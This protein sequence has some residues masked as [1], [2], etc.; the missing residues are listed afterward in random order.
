MYLIAGA[1][2]SL[3]GT[4]ARL[5]LEEGRQVRAIVRASSPGRASARHTT[6]E[7]LAAMGAELVEA[8]LT[9]PASLEGICEGVTAVV[10]TASATKRVAPDT[11]ESVDVAGTAN[12]AE[13][14]ARSGV[15]QFVGIS[16][17][18]ASPD[19]PAAIFRIKGRAEEAIRESGVPFTILQPVKF[20]QDWIGFVLG[21]QLESAGRIQLVGA[22]DTISTFVDEGDV[23]RLAVAVVGSEQALGETLPLAA[24]AASY[25]DIIERIGAIR[26][27]AI[28]WSSVEPGQVVDT[29]DPSLAPTV[30]ALLTIQAESPSDAMV[31]P[32]T[33]ERFG[34][35]LKGIDDFLTTTIT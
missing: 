23:A 19:H 2:G 22:G 9:V 34:L 1:T 17:V 5:L 31:F 26:G 16:T 30:T 15:G 14:A 11:T 20:M 13:A 28:D 4:I 24:E 12:L 29:V 3:G 7:A 6:P 35:E 27:K 32:E 10:C 33:A 21:A 25:R 8:D 18:G